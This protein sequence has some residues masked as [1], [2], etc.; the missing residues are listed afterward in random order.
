MDEERRNG[1]P[2]PEEQSPPQ[3]SAQMEAPVDG[4][5]Q[6][7]AL[8]TDVEE[9]DKELSQMRGTLQRV[10]AD[11]IN[12]KRRAGEEREDQQKFANT[13]LVLKLLPVL[14]DFD[15]AI[16]HASGTEVE[17][18]WLEGIKL[19]HRKLVSLVES[20]NATKI[21][22]E[23]RDFDP[24]EHEAMAY[25]ESADHRQGEILSVVRDGYKIHSRVIRPALVILAKEPEA[26]EEES[27]ASEG[28]ETED[29]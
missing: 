5:S 29:A 2:D 14:D 26:A 12:F 17:A 8:A 7:D 9:Y 15:L 19:I 27:S 16:D 4:E 13:R 1:M 6:P 11:F 21:E 20:E 28:K 24:I 18:P 22:A 25:Q 10:Q 23:G 3:E